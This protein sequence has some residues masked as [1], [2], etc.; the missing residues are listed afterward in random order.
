MNK[1]DYQ[2]KDSATRAHFVGIQ[3]SELKKSQSTA[4]L[5]FILRP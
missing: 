3:Q 1:D 5:E 2:L 4:Y